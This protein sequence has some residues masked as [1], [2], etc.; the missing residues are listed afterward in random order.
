[1]H[2]SVFSYCPTNRNRTVPDQVVALAV[3]LVS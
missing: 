3:A 1:M 2:V